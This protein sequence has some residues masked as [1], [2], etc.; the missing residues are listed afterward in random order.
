[1][2]GKKFVKS[3]GSINFYTGTFPLFDG[4]DS[5]SFEVEFS[6]SAKDGSYVGDWRTGELLADYGTIFR[7][8]TFRL[9]R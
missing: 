3:R 1:M 8:M 7:P 6:E 9:R 2:D 5:G 4:P